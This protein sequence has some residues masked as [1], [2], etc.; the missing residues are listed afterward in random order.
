VEARRNL[1]GRVMGNRC[2]TWHSAAKCSGRP[3]CT[4]TCAETARSLGR[5]LQECGGPVIE[6]GLAPSPGDSQS[7]GPANAGRCRPPTLLTLPASAAQYRGRG[8]S[9]L[10]LFPS[11]PHGTGKGP[12]RGFM[13]T[14]LGLALAADDWRFYPLRRD[15]KI[16]NMPVQPTGLSPS[17]RSGR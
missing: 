8:G 14:T 11:L 15:V 4:D 2:E 9:G 6:C 12:R 5:R 10:T 7:S 3:A 1:T 17:S 16:R 13:S